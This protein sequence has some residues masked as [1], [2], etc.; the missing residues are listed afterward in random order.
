MKFT[1][2]LL[3]GLIISKLYAQPIA[4]GPNSP[5]TTLNCPTCP[6]TPWTNNPPNWVQF[7]L[8]PDSFSTILY[9]TKFGFSVPT[10]ATI[11]GIKLRYAGDFLGPT[12]TDTLMQLTYNG[13]LIG[14]NMALDSAYTQIARTYGDSLNLWGATLTPAMVNDT[15]FG[16]GLRIETDAQAINGGLPIPTITIYYQNPITG[17]MEST[18]SGWINLRYSALENSILLENISG[19]YQLSVFDLQGK[20]V[21]QSLPVGN[22]K[23]VL[24]TPLKTGVYIG[25]LKDENGDTQLRG[26]FLIP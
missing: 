18:Q 15:T 9:Y 12:A 11:T 1:L 26:K 3:L 16:A 24:P 10:G 23:V 2:V 17:L 13:A 19:R 5:T 14:S 20:Q 4:I 6:G 7:F 25:S 21:L 22:N 8:P